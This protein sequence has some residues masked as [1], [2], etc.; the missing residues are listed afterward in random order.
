MKI[1]HT[2]DWHLG[3]TLKGQNLL[4]DQKFILDEIFDIIRDEKPD[5]IL[6]AGDVYDRG[7]PPAEAVELFDE[8]LTK[9]SEKKIPTLIIAGNHDSPK[10]LD[11]GSKIFERQKIFIAAK[12]SD[13]PK[14]VVLED[15]F[16][17]IYFSMIPFFEP[18]EIKA[19]FFDED[20]ERP[21]YNEANRFYVDLARKKIPAGKRS[22]AMAH[23]F[24]TGGEESDS[25]RKIVGTLANVDAKIFSAYNY[26]ALG[27]LHRPQKFYS[28]SP[29]KYSFDEAAQ[30]KSV[31]LVDIDGAGEVQ[32]KK[33]PLTPR[34]DVRVVSGTFDELIKFSRTDDYICAKLT[35]RVINAQDKLAW[36]FPNLLS[37]EVAFQKNSADENSAGQFGAGI[38]T[39]DYF[40][41][42]FKAQTGENLSDDYREA[43][44]ILLEGLRKTGY[45]KSRS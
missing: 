16:G 10:R 26:V 24:L 33:I 38:S 19:K 20:S 3:K 13:E 18:G 21:T 40:A 7:V 43:V 15:D 39:L 29:L 32:T 36:T 4:D 28:G 1:L 34:R 8:T 30:K 14:N 23:V 12:I 17:E 45:E 2:A 9:L 5:A 11:F 27:H 6:I 31:T 35:E 37:V 44:S 42:F 25:E 22:V 41:D